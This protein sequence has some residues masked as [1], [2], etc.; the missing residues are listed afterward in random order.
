MLVRQRES[1]GRQCLGQA[2]LH[3][4]AMARWCQ[5][6]HL[7][8]QMLR[9]GPRRLRRYGGETGAWCSSVLQ[10]CCGSAQRSFTSA[11]SWRTTAARRAAVLAPALAWLSVCCSSSARCG[12]SLNIHRHLNAHQRTD[13]CS[14]VCMPL[15]RTTPYT[16]LGAFP[17]LA[18]VHAAAEQRKVQLVPE[19]T[20][21]A[22]ITFS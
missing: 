15:I 3:A 21:A 20:Q 5:C 7:G 4:Q 10:A 14:G 8:V 2:C 1:S 12:W 16:C 11:S 9:P 18:S 22:S 6:C 17:G 13:V 19:Q